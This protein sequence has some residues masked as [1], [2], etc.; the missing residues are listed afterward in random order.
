MRTLASVVLRL[1]AVVE[2]DYPVDAQDT[3][4]R[5][6]TAIDALRANL[7]VSQPEM[8][9]FMA[10]ILEILEDNPRSREE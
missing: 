7:F 10:D 5:Y 3:R 8:I 6:G 1:W 2:R 9:S 4:I